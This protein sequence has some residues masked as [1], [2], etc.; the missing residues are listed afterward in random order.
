MYLFQHYPSQCYQVYASI[1]GWITI[2]FREAIKTL[3]WALATMYLMVNITLMIF[4]GKVILSNVNKVK[5]M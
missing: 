1:N 3:P 2:G 5:R 4:K